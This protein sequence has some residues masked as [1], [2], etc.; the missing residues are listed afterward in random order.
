MIIISYTHLINLKP[1]HYEAI[2]K[3]LAVLT[4]MKIMLYNNLTH[5]H[6]LFSSE[7]QPPLTG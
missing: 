4:N 3:E 1:V 6:T 7:P 5:N 2:L